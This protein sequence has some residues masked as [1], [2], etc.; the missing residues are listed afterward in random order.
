MDTP[1]DP[2]VQKTLRILFVISLMTCASVASVAAQGIPPLLEP[3]PG[4]TITTDPVT[5]SGAHTSADLKH[6]LRIG[7]SLGGSNLF[8]QSLGTGH[9]A[10]V[11]GL[12]SSGPIYVSY[13]T[14]NSAGWFVNRVVYTMDVGSG[15]PRVWNCPAGD[16]DCLINA[17]TIG[18]GSGNPEI[19]RL[20][21]GTYTITSFYT[22]GHLL[23]PITGNITIEGAETTGTI[24][25]STMFHDFLQTF[26]VDTLG[27][28][29]LTKLSIMGGGTGVLNL[30]NAT[31]DKVTISHNTGIGVGIINRQ[32]GT[33][34][35]RDSTVAYYRGDEH[36]GG[37]IVNSGAMQLIGSTIE[38]NSRSA[39]GGIINSRTGT[40][41]INTSTI[42]D[43]SADFVGAGGISNRGQ[44]ELH[45]TL[46]QNNFGATVGGLE[47][48]EGEINISLSVF[49]G[50]NTEEGFG[51][52]IFN[53]GPMTISKSV[54]ALNKANAGA[55]IFNF[56]ADLSLE[57]T[58]ILGNEAA[59][60]GGGI[61]N[62]GNGRLTLTE[63]VITNNTPDD[64]V[65]CP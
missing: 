40:M 22:G 11:S 48:Q 5:F 7:S 9:S 58:V 20:E 2:F 3:P 29:K 14:L 31:L 63:T 25:R 27:T 64:C 54:I 12:P 10:T 26:E 18:N 47:N 46:V 8:S 57:Q 62:G 42:T 45:N 59:S 55:G 23:P 6:L 38:Q 34:T 43:N 60:N 13:W 52:A 36:S 39:F 49:T 16:T 53:S 17:I 1:H 32:T 65:G 44:M 61:K 51:G 24:I 35:I 4:S 19:I 41:N 50:N 15:A 37:G 21:S 28:L 30:G 33:I 56:G